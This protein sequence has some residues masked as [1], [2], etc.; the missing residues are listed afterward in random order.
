MARLLNVHEV[1]AQLGISVQSVWA[2][3]RAGRIPRSVKLGTCT[4]W[5]SN[6]IDEF[7]AS[8]SSGEA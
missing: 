6:E 7:I 2:W 5:R 8:L 4:R 1:S 3:Q